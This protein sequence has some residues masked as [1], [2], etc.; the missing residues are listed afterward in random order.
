M[1]NATTTNEVYVVVWKDMSEL[2]VTEGFEAH[3]TVPGRTAI[4]NIMTKLSGFYKENINKYLFLYLLKMIKG[5][6]TEIESL[7]VPSPPLLQEGNAEVL[8]KNLKE[9]LVRSVRL[10]CYCVTHGKTTAQSVLRENVEE[11]KTLEEMV[12]GETSVI[13]DASRLEILSILDQIDV[14][15]PQAT[16]VDVI[17]IL[18]KISIS[19]D[20]TC[21]RQVASKL[22]KLVAE[23]QHLNE[24]KEA[25]G[26]DTLVVL[27]FSTLSVGLLSQ[28]PNLFVCMVQGVGV[29]RLIL[30]VTVM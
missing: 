23:K 8:L 14:Q 18:I 1:G 29:W 3:T 13:L 27:P 9:L 30:T 26:I 22:R 17:K 24:L 6:R 19:E 20:Q 28:K 15:S 12:H 10:L 7:L 11:R 21:R 5:T 16:V 25:G 2:M 4:I